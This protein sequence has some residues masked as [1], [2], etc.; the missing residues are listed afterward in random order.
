M[1]EKRLTLVGHLE[2]LRKRIIIIGLVVVIGSV[3]SYLYI[4]KI[5]DFIIQP[6]KDL[7]FI[8]LS[9]ADLFLAYIK[10]SLIS[11]MIVTLPIIL[12]H[13]W[14][15]VLP[16]MALKQKLYIILA[17]FM[18]MIFF[19]AGASFAY[20]LIVPL[21]IQFFTKMSRQEIEPL[22]SFAS[23]TGFMSSILL[24]FGITFQLPILILLLTQ[25]NIITPAFLKKSRKVFILIIFIAAAILTPPDVVSQILLAAPMLIL[26]ELSIMI[27]SIIYRKK[28][29]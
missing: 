14:R 23:Y 19:V 17:N 5:V 21:T 29:R 24:S 18:S 8:Y 12:Y 20:Y 3:V 28:R 10:I 27:S 2:E 1:N 9:P 15:F 26:L 16:G 25:F 6:A 7:N 4:D 11:G 13:V 22:F